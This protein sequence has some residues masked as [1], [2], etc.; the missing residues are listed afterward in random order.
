[1]SRADTRSSSTER[2]SQSQKHRKERAMKRSKFNA[3]A[4]FGGGYN[5]YRKEASTGKFVSETFERRSEV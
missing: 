4:I 5:A 2:H 1:M 3:S